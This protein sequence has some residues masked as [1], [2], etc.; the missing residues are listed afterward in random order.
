MIFDYECALSL[1]DELLGHYDHSH[2][3]V[4]RISTGLPR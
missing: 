3:E 1:P 2:I 4:I